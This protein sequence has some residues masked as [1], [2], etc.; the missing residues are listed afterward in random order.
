MT[1]K[2]I[3]GILYGTV[4]SPDSGYYDRLDQERLFLSRDTGGPAEKARR[5]LHY[6]QNVRGSLLR[7]KDPPTGSEIFAEWKR[8]YEGGNH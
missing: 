6:L 2:V 3:R 8:V 1:R 4:E 7:F 5:A